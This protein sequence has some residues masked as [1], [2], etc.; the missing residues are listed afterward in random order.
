MARVVSPLM[1]AVMTGCMPSP[2]AFFMSSMAPTRLLMEPCMDLLCCSSMPWNLP[3]SSVADLKASATM[4]AEMA[5]ADISSLSSLMLLP[6]F[7]LISVSGLKPALIIWSKSCPMSLP[8]ADICE[9]ASVSDWNR[10]ASP[11]LMSPICLRVG[12]TFS[13]S[14][15]KPSII[16]APLARVL[17]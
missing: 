14:M 3:P 4:S 2:M 12:M 10:C 17:R 8:V 6:V 5:P 16:C 13:A 1:P 15:L 9:K 11:M 7:R